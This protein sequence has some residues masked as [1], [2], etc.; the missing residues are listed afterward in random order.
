MV[1]RY[2]DGG[3]LVYEVCRYRTAEGK[4]TFKIHTPHGWGLNG[5]KAILYNKIRGP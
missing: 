1:H 2:A 4:K 3:K 5:Q